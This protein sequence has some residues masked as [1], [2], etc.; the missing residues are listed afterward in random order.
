MN[1]ELEP[2]YSENKQ[3]LGELF[4]QFLGYYSSFNYE[5]HAISIRMASVI[6]IVNC[7]LVPSPKNDPHQWKELCI[8]EPFDLTNTA[9][10][11]YDAETFL[12]I[13]DVFIT[14]FHR[15]KETLDLNVLFETSFLQP[16]RPLSCFTINTIES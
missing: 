15:L 7:R 8:E 11:V 4:L 16:P 9:R 10:S 5:Q 2:F 3:T 14:S 12:R 6:P 1:E 13:K